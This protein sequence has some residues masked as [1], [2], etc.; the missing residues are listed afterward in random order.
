M[1]TLD[2]LNNKKNNIINLLEK[3]Y[4]QNISDIIFEG[5]EYLRDI[6]EY[7]FSLQKA[8]VIYTNG[9]KDEIYLKIIKGGKIKESIFCYW[10]LLYDEYLK[11]NQS[12]VKDMLQKA[13]ITQITSD[14]KKSSL[15]L[16]INSE[17]N[18]YAQIELIELGFLQEKYKKYGR[19]V[20]NLDIEKDQILFIA[21]KMY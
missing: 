6:A 20:K 15:I 5:T 2:I 3:V 4:N 17:L 12:N 21:R 18:H 9:D 1:E 16:T 8:K 19:W 10:S 13:I 7:D 11:E 14:E